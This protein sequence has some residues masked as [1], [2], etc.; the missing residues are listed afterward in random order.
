M[1]S[2]GKSQAISV[3]VRCDD[4]TH[5]IRQLSQHVSGQPHAHSRLQRQSKYGF[6]ARRIHV[7]LVNYALD[8][9]RPTDLTPRPTG[10]SVR[11]FI[12]RF[13]DIVHLELFRPFPCEPMLLLRFQLFNVQQRYRRLGPSHQRARQKPSSGMQGQ[14]ATRS[15]QIGHGG[16]GAKTAF[17]HYQLRGQ[18]DRRSKV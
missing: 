10:S 18:E 8:S 13:W 7:L 11:G 16:H 2:E 1:S 5:R 17:R 6:R 15:E 9:A 3:N 12:A 14:G 4:H